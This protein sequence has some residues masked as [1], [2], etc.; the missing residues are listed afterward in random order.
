M[1]AITLCK[2]IKKY[3]DYFKTSSCRNIVSNKEDFLFGFDL[4]LINISNYF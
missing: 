3:Y 4:K 1:Q 2:L